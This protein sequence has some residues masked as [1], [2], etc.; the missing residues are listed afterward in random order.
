MTMA[1]NW[2]LVEFT[3]AISINLK[4]S[5]IFSSLLLLKSKQQTDEKILYV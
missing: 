1:E 5:V 2:M 3:N 4:A